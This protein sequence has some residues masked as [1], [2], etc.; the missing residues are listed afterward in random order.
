MGVD[1]SNEVNPLQP[2]S[3]PGSMPFAGLHQAPPSLQT[4]DPFQQAI[5]QHVMV[6]GN[7]QQQQQQQYLPHSFGGG[8]VA[9]L[10]AQEAAYRLQQRLMNEEY[11]LQQLRQTLQTQALL[12][13]LNLGGFGASGSNNNVLNH[14]PSNNAFAGGFANSLMQQSMNNNNQDVLLQ[15]ALALQ[16][17]QNAS[18]SG[19]MQQ[20]AS[21][22]QML[23]AAAQSQGIDAGT[24]AQLLMSQGGGVSL[25]PS[26]SKPKD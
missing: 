1:A 14:M 11:R 7:A 2:S 17:N 20:P 4:M 3:F 26:S 23:L 6:N 10:P 19:V 18:M 22:E 15:Q 5:L 8:N 16:A 24:L 13:Y 21:N 12:P 9:D 25:P